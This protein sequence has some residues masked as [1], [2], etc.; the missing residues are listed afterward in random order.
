MSRAND[1][2]RRQWAM[3]LLFVVLLASALLFESAGSSGHHASV[4]SRVLGGTAFV[5]FAL[6]RARGAFVERKPSAAFSTAGLLTIAFTDF[7]QSGGPADPAWLKALA[8]A[9]LAL[10]VASIPFAIVLWR[11]DRDERERAIV[12]AAT[13]VAFV[14]TMLAVLT[15]V[16]LDRYLHVARVTPSWILLAGAI[17]WFGAWF[18]L[19]ER[20]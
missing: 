15:F 5:L 8:V 19:Q 13:T 7:I 10:I 12:N 4:R 17:S 1:S 11:R 3:A 6:S 2:P 18:V 14:T 20:M 16:L 9:T